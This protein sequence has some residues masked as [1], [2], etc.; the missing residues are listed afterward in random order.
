MS[1]WST[2]QEDPFASEIFN[3]SSL[4]NSIKPESMR[5]T[6]WIVKA[7]K[8]PPVSDIVNQV[9]KSGQF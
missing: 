7:K 1:R 3:S 2:C 5:D 6:C 8:I 4:W 9:L